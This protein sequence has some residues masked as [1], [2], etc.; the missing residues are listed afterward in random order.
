[1]IARST[2]FLVIV[3]L[4][5]FF[6]ADLVVHPTQVLYSDH[7]DLLAEHVPAKR[8]LVRSFRETGELPLWCPYSFAGSAFVHDPQ[9]AMFYPP[10]WALL[11]LPE[12][13]VGAGLSWLVVLHVIVAGWGTYLCTR[14]EG[15]G[16]PAALVAAC[17][18]MFAGKWMLHLLAAGHYV[19][20]GLAWLPWVLLL[21]E[22]ALRRRSFRWATA[23]GVVFALV[24][25]GTHPQWTFYAGL[26]LALWTLGTALE[27]AGVWPSPLSPR[28]RGVGGEGDGWVA[29]RLPV[30]H[31][32]HTPDPS[33]PR[34][35][36]RK[37]AAAVLRWAGYGAWAAALAA[38]L[39]AVQLLPTLEA[40]ELSTRAGGVAPDEIVAGGLRS[41]L[42][43]VGPALKPVPSSL[44]WEDRGGLGLLWVA[45]AALAPFLC[46]G[47][48]RYQ[49][50]VCLALVVFALGGAIV[51]Q[52]LPGFRVFR[53]PARMLLIVALPV[54]LLAGSATEALFRGAAPAPGRRVLAKLTVAAVILAGG[55]AVRMV[56]QGEVPRWH[57]Y[58]A[59]LLVTLP[60][61]FWVLSNQYSVLSTR[62]GQLL[63]VLVLF[64]DLWALARPLATVRPEADVYRPSECVAHLPPGGRVLDR[65]APGLE[66]GTPLGAGAPLALLT[67]LEPLRGYNPLDNRRYKEYLQFIA[68]ADEP[69]RPLDGPLT[70]PVVGNFPVRNKSL[71]DL[72][73]TSYALQ[74]S[75][76]GDDWRLDGPG[77]RVV[78]EDAAPAGYDFATGGRQPL[79][80]YTVYENTEALPRAFVVP[81]A[82]PLPDR[83]LVLDTLAATDF[84]AR[85]LLEGRDGPAR[86]GGAAADYRPAELLEYHPNRV[87][88]AVEPGAPGFLVLADVWYPGWTCTVDGRPAP[89]YRADYLFRAV[90]LPEG[91]REVEFRF[92]PESY[93]LGRAVSLAA[94]VLVA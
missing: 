61:A 36:G 55:F 12:E 17:G 73:G 86:P 11:L 8:F 31:P 77:W 4:A 22:E 40:A 71:L 76:L 84:R 65:D 72:L 21:L 38:A 32:P 27:G 64:L 79:P 29:L 75:G 91:A 56:I 58:W 54:A 35:E 33:P 88:V 63:W 3:A 62:A 41:L 2:P 45:A 30:S 50:A 14:G 16:K 85:V 28:G 15:L 93:R 7:S 87:R 70:F 18:F 49:A 43:F 23:A 69:L 92:E 81:E 37:V 94:L 47:R 67:G 34:G 20:V 57:V 89:L 83:A 53:Q 5:L 52:A 51:F 6:F 1:M 74:P 46:R 90:E 42:F 9:V 10:H 78:G 48:V 24:V 82:A 80:P 25:L 26:F 44:M 59:S 19:T 68:G 39:A 13:R 60:T 66:A